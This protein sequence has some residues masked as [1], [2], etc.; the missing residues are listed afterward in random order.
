MECSTVFPGQVAD[1]FQKSP[2]MQRYFAEVIRAERTVFG[3]PGFLDSRIRTMALKMGDLSRVE[4][5]VL[6]PA[7]DAD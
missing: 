6:A 2:V 4:A 5:E 3:E 1:F 7:L